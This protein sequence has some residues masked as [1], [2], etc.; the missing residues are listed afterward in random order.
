MLTFF[1]ASLNSFH[2][3]PRFVLGVTLFINELYILREPALL[4]L[5]QTD[6]SYTDL[7]NFSTHIIYTSWRR[8]AQQAL[9]FA[10]AP[11]PQPSKPHAQI[12]LSNSHH[13]KFDRRW[14]SPALKSC[15][16]GSSQRTDRAGAVSSKIS[17]RHG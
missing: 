16:I 11:T 17:H 10:H 1:Y 6:L 8:P 4:Q 12:N 14:H 15:L 3:S 9:H 7:F 5:N 2:H 13:V